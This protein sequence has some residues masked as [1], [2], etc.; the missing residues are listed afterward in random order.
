M[1]SEHP[2]TTT[3]A[4]STAARR[5]AAALAAAGFA[6]LAAASLGTQAGASVAATNERVAVTGFPAAL[7]SCLNAS[8]R[9]IAI[10]QIDDSYRAAAAAMGLSIPQPTQNADTRFD[11]EGSADNL[12]LQVTYDLSVNANGDVTV[13][14]LTIDRICGG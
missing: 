7:G 12:R 6:A 9:E 11:T 4:R 10:Q 3:T 14:G 8:S 2:S 1:H 13:Q 5:I